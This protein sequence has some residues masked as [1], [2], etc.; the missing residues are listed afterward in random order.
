MIWVESVSLIVLVNGM[1]RETFK[2][3]RGL[4]QGDMLSLYLSLLCAEGLS[5]HLTRE[6]SLY[7]ISSIKVLKIALVITHLFFPNDTTCSFFKDFEKECQVL[8]EILS[9]YEKASNQAIN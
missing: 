9:D 5:T 6:E 8:K 1:L 7:N 3:S 2:P 4:H